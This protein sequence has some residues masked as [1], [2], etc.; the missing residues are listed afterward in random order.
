MIDQSLKGFHDPIYYLGKRHGLV[1]KKGRANIEITAKTITVWAKDE[2]R[3]RAYFYRK[4]ALKLDELINTFKDKYEEVLKDYGY[5]GQIIIKY[6]LLK[7][8]WGACISTEGIIEINELLIHYPSECLEAVFWHECVH[9]V[10]NGH[11]R[12]FYEVL[13]KQMPNYR[14]IQKKMR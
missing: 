4:A 14:E 6:R 12:D 8:R 13:L 1:L 2:K 3:A 9:F 11:R 5:N 10:R 7:S